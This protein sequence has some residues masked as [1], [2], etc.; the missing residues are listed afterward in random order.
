MCIRDRDHRGASQA[1]Y[2][3]GKRD[4]ESNNRLLNTL[5]ELDREKNNAVINLSPQ[6][7]T[8]A[9]APAASTPTPKSDAGWTDGANWGGRTTK[10]VMKT[11]RTP[12]GFV[13]RAVEAP[14][15]AAPT[16]FATAVQQ[17]QE[18]KVADDKAKTKEMVEANR[19]EAASVQDA[20]TLKRR[21][22]ADSNLEIYRGLVTAFDA[23]NS[24]N[25][26]IGE[27]VDG[28]DIDVTTG[29]RRGEGNTRRGFVGKGIISDINKAMR[30]SGNNFVTISGIVAV[31]D[32]EGDDPYFIVRGTKNKDGSK[33]EQVM[34]LDDVA[35]FARKNYSTSSNPMSNIDNEL[36]K[37]FNGTSWSERLV[38]KLRT[39]PEYRKKLNDA[40]AT[41]RDSRT[42]EKTIE[43]TI[44]SNKMKE[45]LENKKHELNAKKVENDAQQAADALALDR[46]K[47]NET[48][49]KNKEEEAGRGAKRDH[50]QV[51]AET[52]ALIKQMEI[53]RRSIDDMTQA[54]DK[55]DDAQREI[56]NKQIAAQRNQ[57]KLYSQ[58]LNDLWGYDTPQDE[59]G[60]GS[61]GGGV[62]E[63]NPHGSY[64]AGDRFTRNGVV[65]EVGTDGQP[66]KV[67]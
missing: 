23:L 58:S 51:V 35:K 44:R 15:V 22:I 14:K 10:T 36:I 61:N 43:E 21:A 3:A 62:Q 29:Y 1:E 6:P 64:K 57:L 19:K 47:H 39:D 12:W 7:T 38:G 24:T 9:S 32:G 8:P 2:E 17:Q 18:A 56:L 25:Q 46:D 13:S 42:R 40:D 41:E 11:V 59:E 33:Y 49:R 63:F 48:V 55:A 67:K 27:V 52:N 34:T 53:T 66:H 20:K 65:Y 26:S 60:V 54:L 16:S 4:W 28:V 50:E 5:D 31:D 45:E 37:D 30:R